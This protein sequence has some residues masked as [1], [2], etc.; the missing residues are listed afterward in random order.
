[1][2]PPEQLVQDRLNTLIDESVSVLVK[3]EELVQV[4]DPYRADMQAAHDNNVADFNVNCIP[5]PWTPSR[6]R[7]QSL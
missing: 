6:E 4:V 7:F 2:L 1:M 5:R 3:D